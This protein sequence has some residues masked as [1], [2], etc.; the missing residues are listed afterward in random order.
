V[1][2]IVATDDGTVVESFDTIEESGESDPSAPSPWGD[3]D[4]PMPVAAMV[5][6]LQRACASALRAALAKAD[7]KK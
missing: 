3:L 7:G 6:D 2:I 1:R 5:G 4:K